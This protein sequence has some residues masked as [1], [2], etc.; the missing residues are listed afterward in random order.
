MKPIGTQNERSVKNSLSSY[1][2]RYYEES[3]VVQEMNR[4][5]AEELELLYLRVTDVLSQYFVDTATWGLDRWEQL[6]Q[7]TTDELKTYEERRGVIRS[8]IRRYGTSTAT[9]IKNVAESYLNGEVQLT[10]QNSTY[11]LNVKFVGKR[12]IPTNLEDI[13]SAIRAVTPAHL[14]IF[15]EFT[16]LVW[17]ELEG[18]NFNWNTMDTKT[19]NALEGSFPPA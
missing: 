12:G 14:G 5:D 18:Q 19:W 8:R 11:N 2:P 15:Y 9:M 17:S 1:R 4:V 13:K 3:I 6:F 16:Y 10:E 7:I